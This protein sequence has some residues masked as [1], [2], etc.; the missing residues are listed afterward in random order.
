MVDVADGSIGSE[1]LHCGLGAGED[2]CVTV[3]SR[4]SFGEVHVTSNVD[5][6]E[7]VDEERRR[8]RGNNG[9]GSKRVEPG[10]PGVGSQGFEGSAFEGRG[11]SAFEAEKVGAG[12]DNGDGPER[13]GAEEIEEEV[14]VGRGSFGILRMGEG[15][16]EGVAGFKHMPEMEWFDW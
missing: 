12:E 11:A 14:I 9:G 15:D 6:E 5:G 16:V 8:E 2:E 4:R 3:E 7:K 10:L 1:V 13:E